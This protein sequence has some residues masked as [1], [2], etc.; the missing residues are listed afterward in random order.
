VFHE[1]ENKKEEAMN[2]KDMFNAKKKPPS[3]SLQDR[4]LRM[5]RRQYDFSRISKLFQTHSYIT[6]KEA[7]GTPPGKYHII[8]H[9]D[10]LIQTGKSIEAK[11]EHTLELT[12]PER[13]PNESPQA[14]M[15]TGLFHPNVSAEMID[16][17]GI[18]N[19]QTALADLIVNIGQLIAFQQYATDEPLNSE[20]A[21]WA[22]RNKSLLPLSDVDLGYQ[23][24]ED[25]ANA[26]MD[27]KPEIN[28]TAVEDEN[29]S[30]KTKAIAREDGFTEL[31]EDNDP[32]AET[33]SID[34]EESS[35]LQEPLKEASAE[36]PVEEPAKTV[37]QAKTGDNKIVTD[38]R[39][40]PMIT[41]KK[42][43]V[44]KKEG[45]K[46]KILSKP[47]SAQISINNDST[48][49][50]PEILQKLGIETN[51]EKNSEQQ[52]PRVFKIENTRVTGTMDSRD[53][54]INSDAYLPMR[55]SQA[56]TG[57]F[58]S[59]CGIRVEA[60]ANYCGRCGA[61]LRVKS[62]QRLARI[63]LILGL[64]AIPIIIFEVGSLI[65]ILNKKVVAPSNAPAPETV[66]PVM[67]QPATA[68]EVAVKD[69][70]TV[71]RMEPPPALEKPVVTVSKKESP[72]EVTDAP[73]PVFTKV[74]APKPAPVAIEAPKPV[75]AKVE[76]PKP[77][78]AVVE[79]QKPV[80][81]ATEAPKPSPSVTEPLK[82]APAATEAQK[83]AQVTSTP[84]PA[85]PVTGSAKKK[86]AIEGYLGSPEAVAPP[87][88]ITKNAAANQSA[89]NDNLKLAR[90]YMGIGS[91]D[92]AI[93]RFRDV[94]KVD[95]YNQEAI[96]GLMQAK[97]MKAMT[98]G[99]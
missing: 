76:A 32:A 62:S 26:L 68:P 58:C 43:D 2:I 77:A 72:A 18:W 96:Q 51:V 49:H 21:Q 80:P 55:L 56:T 73:K 16:L 70:K 44:R 45:R 99:K 94:V 25:A 84:A 1:L 83:A 8:Y 33:V 81:A 50:P 42:D 64:I 34:R 89:V 69:K 98:S 79:V 82:P 31:G 30:E 7:I 14:R 23:E 9:V 48:V 57:P 71:V 6:I 75:P 47:V 60:Y 11:N 36:K 20:A 39:K 12:L 29:D 38:G 95:P 67:D 35:G 19:L 63:F 61:K 10:G 13:Y 22:L 88:E 28:D 91:Y 65:F 3:D 46:E 85:A 27:T 74:E 40:D 17:K 59:H 53:K 86:A 5:Q 4:E 97:K 87:A 15:V 90:L 24:I 54:E 93:T 41:Q 66:Q 92:D 37:D 78:P 52:K